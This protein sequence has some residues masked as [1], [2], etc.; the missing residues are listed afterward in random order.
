MLHPRRRALLRKRNRTQAKLQVLHSLGRQHQLLAD[1]RLHRRVPGIGNDHISR[2]WPGPS[3][4]VGPADRADHV[5]TAL[6]D[7]PRQLSD[8]SDPGDQVAVA[9]EQ[10]TAKE[11][12]FDSRQTQR[13]PVLTE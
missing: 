10:M 4:L 2:L 11:M 8:I 3:E 5:V 7:H 9:G 1:A 6:Y 13:E 12:G